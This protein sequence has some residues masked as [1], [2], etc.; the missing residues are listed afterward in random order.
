MRVIVFFSGGKDSHASLIWAVRKWGA[1]NCIAVFCDTQWEHVLLYPFIDEVCEK[2]GVELVK[3]QSQYSFLELA[4]KKNRFPSTKARF[5]TEELKVKPAINY[6][7]Q[8]LE[9]TDYIIVIQGIRKDESISR[10]K[11]QAHCQYFKYYFTPYGHDKDGKP[12][13]FNYR[14]KDIIRLNALSKVDIERP[15]FEYNSG[16]VID[17]IM[18]AGHKPNP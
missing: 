9:I 15:M 16:A 8:T 13:T 3:I 12:K 1:K 17:Y 2:L 7:L 4:I 5:C 11:M 18:Q 10:S 6:I 14:K